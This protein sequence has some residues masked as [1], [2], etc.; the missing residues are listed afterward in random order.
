VPRVVAG[1]GSTF[2]CLH[3]TQAFLRGP[4]WVLMASKQ[5]GSWMLR[6]VQKRTSLQP[7]SDRQKLLHVGCVIRWPSFH[8]VIRSV[9]HR[10]RGMGMAE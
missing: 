7:E 3:S 1:V 6:N 5:Y 2:C 10:V 4:V 9:V 8:V